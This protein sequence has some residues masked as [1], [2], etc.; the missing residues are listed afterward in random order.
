MDNPLLKLIVI[1]G[2]AVS[3]LA[4]CE[5]TE[6]T[7]STGTDFTFAGLA[8]TWESGCITATDGIVTN[9]N[10]T[11]IE[12]TMHSNG[13]FTHNQYWFTGGSCISYAIM[14]TSTGSYTIGSATGYLYPLAFT[15][16]SSSM[17]AWNTSVQSAVNTGCGG[18]SPYNSTPSTGD[19]GQSKSTYMMSCY[20]MTL[21]NSGNKFVDNVGTLS[22]GV[23]SLGQNQN[24]V[25]GVFQGGSVPTSTS[26]DF[27]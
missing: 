15:V 6:E 7:P 8:K 13:A 16:T 22:N 4:A 23:L 2:L 3:T 14:Y 1:M 10:R 12:L 9:A 21:P 27:Y 17:M 18:T 5:A 20:S 19:N 11:K 25:P 26:V 24:G